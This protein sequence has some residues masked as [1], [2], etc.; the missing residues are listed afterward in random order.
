MRIELKARAAGARDGE[1]IARVDVAVQDAGT[2]EPPRW[3]GSAVASIIGVAGAVTTLPEISTRLPSRAVLV[4]HFIATVGT[5]AQPL[6]VTV[7]AA[8]LASLEHRA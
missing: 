2:N 1:A 7:V 5:S 8:L 3:I 6:I 4:L